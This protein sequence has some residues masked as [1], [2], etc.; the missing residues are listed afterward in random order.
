MIQE[1]FHS[2]FIIKEDSNYSAKIYQATQEDSVI[3]NRNVFSNA[4]KNTKKSDYDEYCV[5]GQPHIPFVDEVTSEMICSQCGLVLQDHLL[6]QDFNTFFWTSSEN[7]GKT[8][9]YGYPR[10]PLN[11]DITLSTYTDESE[12]KSP[13]LRNAMKFD[14]RY[15]WKQRNFY[16][17]ILEIKRVGEVLNLPQSIKENA[18]QIYKKI[19]AKGLIKGRTIK[20][21]VI[22]SIF[23]ACRIQHL[24]KSLKEIALSVE[25]KSHDLQHVYMSISKELKLDLPDQKPKEIIFHVL[26]KLSLPVSDLEVISQIYNQYKKL[27]LSIG[28]DPIGIISAI[29]YLFYQ[30]TNKKMIQKVISN[31]LCISE[32]TLRHRVNEIKKYRILQKFSTKKNNIFTQINS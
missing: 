21:V 1:K 15:S 17:A 26:G 32:V 30:E 6:A 28:K 7:L 5:D 23:Y 9:H 11:S 3:S 24:P 19:Y 12:I 8:I 22:I 31:L 16:N 10:S 20:N 14:S 18:F 29:V 13:L 27:N 4:L 25:I 2:T